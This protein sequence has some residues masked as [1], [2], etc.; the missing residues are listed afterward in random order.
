[1]MILTQEIEFER[2][3]WRHSKSVVVTIPHQY[4][5]TDMLLSGKKLKFKMTVPEAKEGAAKRAKG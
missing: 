2:R 3:P 5:T 1:M 4:V